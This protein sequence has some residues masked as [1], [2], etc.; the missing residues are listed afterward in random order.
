M[1]GARSDA[2]QILVVEDEASIRN[3]LRTT[4]EA[5]GHVVHEAEDAREGRTLAGNRRIDLYLVD[6]GLD[7]P[8]F[9]GPVVSG[10]MALN[11]K[12]RADEEEPIH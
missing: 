6:L 3:L 8:R 1:K 12:G 11:P 10:K 2:V 4:L 5:E 9:L 7:V